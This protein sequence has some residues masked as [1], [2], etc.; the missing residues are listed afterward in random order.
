MGYW[1][2]IHERI[3]GGVHERYHTNYVCARCFD[4]GALKE[5]VEAH[6]VRKIC[7]FC[8]T[9]GDDHIAAPFLE[10]IEHMSDSLTREYD[11]AENHLP[12]ESSEGG[13]QGTVWTTYEL[14]VDQLEI[15][16]PQDHDDR[17]LYAI[18]DALGDRAWC[19]A[20]PF[21]LADSDRLRMSWTEFCKIIK[22]RR[23]FFFMDDHDDPHDEL[24]GPEAITDAIGLWC[25]KLDLVAV[26]PPGTR[27]FRARYKDS[28]FELAN[29][30]ELGPPPEEKATQSNRMSPPGIVMFYASDDPETGVR[31]TCTGPGTF[32][33]GEFEI[34]REIKILDLASLP[35][36]PSIFQELP[37][38]LEYDSRPPLIFLRHFAADISK[39]IARDDRIHVEYVPTQ[40]ITEYFRTRFIHAGTPIRGI[41]YPSSRRQGHGSIVLFA[42]QEDLLLEG[43]DPTPYRTREPWLNLMDTR[44]Y[45]VAQEDIDCWSAHAAPTGIDA[46]A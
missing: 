44:R 19:D 45:D 29:A 23:R 43:D 10:I 27:V 32:V 41:R 22:H 40:V 2:D 34:Q 25:Q 39:P 42:T 17:L 35:P 26:L 16:L 38:A 28:G 11:T 33:V 21:S 30:R 46:D 5:F 37:D 20:H 14:L 24:L 1:K 13:Y 9:Q 7:T 31:E 6:A 8:G 12:Y 18:G 3:G 15:E 36:V 4:D